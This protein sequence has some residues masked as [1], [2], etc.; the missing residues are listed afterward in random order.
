MSQQSEMRTLQRVQQAIRHLRRFESHVAVH[1]ADHEVE[2][3][4]R[5]PGK[6]E[7]AVAHDVALDP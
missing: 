1:A 3:R 5:I 7:R 2:L 6:I 4:K